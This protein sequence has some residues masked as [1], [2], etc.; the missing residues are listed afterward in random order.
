[1]N[2]IKFVVILAFGLLQS[3][4]IVAQSMTN[5]SSNMDVYEVYLMSK[6]SSSSIVGVEGSI[7][8]FDE[9]KKG[10]I[11]FTQNNNMND[12]SL[13][14]D[15]LN[16]AIEVRKSDEVFVVSN[17]DKVESVDIEGI[18]YVIRE[19]PEGK[20]F[21]TVEKFGEVELLTKENII[22]KEGRKSTNS[23]SEDVPPS[24]EKEKY[25][26]YIRFGDSELIKLNSN[27]KFKKGLK[28]SELEKLYKFYKNENIKI[29]R[30][31]DLKQL[32]EYYNVN[33]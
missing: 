19:T 8:L 9:F 16:N 33:M 23:Y 20:C 13:R 26:E 12:V 29:G 31:D 18:N 28:N 4:T 32:I 3:L 2:R 24:Y 5:S 6:N 27:R 30:E 1:M 10:S 14:L 21:F 11:T 15:L 25:T 17:I 22:F 7:Y